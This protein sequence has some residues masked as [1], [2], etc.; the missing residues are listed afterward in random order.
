MYFIHI[1]HLP[2]VLQDLPYPPNL[3]LF[4][5]RPK[6]NTTELPQTKKMK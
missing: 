3:K 4:L 5:K 2:Q 6:P 1:H